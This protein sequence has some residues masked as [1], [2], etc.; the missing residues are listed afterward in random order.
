MI[1]KLEKIRVFEAFS[2][3][4]SQKR[5]LENI[6]LP[7]E[8]VAISEIDKFSVQSYEILHGKANNLG[9]ISKV[10]ID[11]IPDHDLFTYSFPCQDISKDGQQKGFNIN[12]NTRSS[13][14]WEC[15]KVI[16]YKKPK[17]LLLENVRSI[18][19]PRHKGDFNLWLE[20]L[21][22]EGYTNS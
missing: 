4:G 9:D 1:Y 2:G 16:H 18:V 22:S 15:Q 6:G 5:A 19:S 10:E 8:M 12:D 7:H 13:L 21:E 14:L 20:W 11:D 17:Y 3:I